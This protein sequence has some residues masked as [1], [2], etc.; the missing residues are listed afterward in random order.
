VIEFSANR[1]LLKRNYL[2]AVGIDVNAAP[3]NRSP[4][5]ATFPEDTVKSADPR[6]PAI[7][8][9]PGRVLNIRAVLLLGAS[10]ILEAPMVAPAASRTK[11]ETV[12]DTELG[13]TMATDVV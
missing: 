1:R 9:K 5:T 3:L 8:P 12:A 2:S 6:F 11:I 10:A 13:L 7:A 4:S